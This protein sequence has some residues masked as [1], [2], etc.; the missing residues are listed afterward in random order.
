MEE[1]HLVVV[2]HAKCTKALVEN[3]YVLMYQHVTDQMWCG[4]NRYHD[5]QKMAQRISQTS[6]PP[7]L[8]HV[9]M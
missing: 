3:A 6:S 9:N 1:T 8:Q 7:W 5:Q 4:R 2:L